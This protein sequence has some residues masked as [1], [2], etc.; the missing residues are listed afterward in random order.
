MR[1]PRSAS[2]RSQTERADPKLADKLL[3]GFDKSPLELRTA[4][5]AY[6]EEKGDDAVKLKVIRFSAPEAID[7]AADAP[8]PNAGRRRRDRSHT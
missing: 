7:P 4:F 2:R 1:Q 8:V 6:K 3:V 5:L